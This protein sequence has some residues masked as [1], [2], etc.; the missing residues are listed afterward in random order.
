MKNKKEKSPIIRKP[1][2]FVLLI[3]LFS[4][5]FFIYP[6]KVIQADIFKKPFI[7]PLEG[8]IIVGFRQEYHDIGKGTT[9]KHTGIDIEGNAG[10]TV[11]ASGNGIVSY[12]GFSPIG[13]L[14]VVIKHNSRIRTTYLNLKSVF[15][16]PGDTV[17][18]GDRIGSIGE[19]DDPS[20]LLPHLHF[21]I[22]Y[23]G[24]YLDPEDV[25]D[26]DYSSISRFIILKYSEEDYIIE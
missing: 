17:C 16:S 1:L 20:S 25:F 10:D 9:R 18:Q 14:T 8:R 21:G 12:R 19:S 3:L 11:Y 15:V 5:V 22:I 4:L 26:I 13:G 2:I 24:Y 23:D 6:E 7:K